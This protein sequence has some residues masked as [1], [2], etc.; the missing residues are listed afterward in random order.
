MKLD[1]E[2]DSG[3]SEIG[4]D[5]D[6]LLIGFDDTTDEGPCIFFETSILLCNSL[7]CTR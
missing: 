2:S 7:L 4:E 3:E 6:D 1:S 5:D